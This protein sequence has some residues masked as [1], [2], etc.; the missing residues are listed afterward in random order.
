MSIW[1]KKWRYYYYPHLF[2]FSAM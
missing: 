2:S 1:I